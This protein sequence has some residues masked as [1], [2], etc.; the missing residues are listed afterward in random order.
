MVIIP[1]VLNITYQYEVTVKMVTDSGYAS[2]TKYYGDDEPR[3]AA[4]YISFK[5]YFDGSKG[6]SV[7]LVRKA[8]YTK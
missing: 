6:N 5:E 2:H 8:L 1:S 3:A 4:D 7:D